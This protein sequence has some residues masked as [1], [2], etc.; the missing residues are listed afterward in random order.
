MRTGISQEINRLPFKY[1]DRVSYG[2]ILSRVTNDVDT[3][4][5]TLNQSIG[6]LVSSATMLVGA[7]IMMFYTNW[8]MALTAIVASVI[9][10]SFMMISMSSSQ[11]YFDEQ[12]NSLGTIN[13]HIEE[14][15]SGHIIVKAYNGRNAAKAT[16]EEINESLFSSG[17]KSQFLSGLMMP[18]MMFIGNFGYVAVCVVGAVL[19]MNGTISFGGGIHDVYP[20]VYTA[21]LAIGTGRSE[22]AK[23]CCSQ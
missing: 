14:I 18:I 16:F 4:G 5:Q 8:I 22:P 9:G 2:D 20:V 11:K 6:T 19:A 12:Q 13:G 17:W 21:T 23:D 1:F 7:L 3:I 10:F 15:Y